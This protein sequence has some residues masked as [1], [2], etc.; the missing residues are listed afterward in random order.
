MKKYFIHLGVMGTIY[1]VIVPV[2]FMVIELIEEEQR[3]HVMMLGLEIG[4]LVLFGWLAILSG[5][6]YSS[7]RKVI[8]KSFM[9]KTRSTIDICVF[10]I[11]YFLYMISLNR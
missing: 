11:K 2:A 9:E 8:N 10:E 6:K 4:R 5:W 3:E 7:Y 1:M